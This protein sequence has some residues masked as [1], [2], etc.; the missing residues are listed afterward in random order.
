MNNVFFISL[1]GA[2]LV[3]LGLMLLWF[4]MDILVRICNH[5][6]AIAREDKTSKPA[7]DELEWEQKA[8]AVSTA[9]ALALQQTLLV[10]PDKKSDT[11]L[12][13]WQ[14]VHRHQQLHSKPRNR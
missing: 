4:L 7:R 5:E 10:A 1:V 2:G 9:I 12:T 14:I 6:N 13:A 3:F 11:C 8:V